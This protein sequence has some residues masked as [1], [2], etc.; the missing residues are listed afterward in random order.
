MTLQ[1]K[2]KALLQE[3]DLYKNQSLLNEAK[4]KFAEVLDLIK[5][6]GSSIK[7]V[8]NV[9]NA[10]SKKVEALEKEIE[11]MYKSATTP[12]VSEKAQNLIKQLFSFSN[13]GNS[14]EANLQAAIALAKFGQHERA[15]KEFKD[16]LKVDSMRLVAAKNVL[17]CLISHTS[18]DEAITQFREWQ[19]NDLFNPQELEKVKVF[20][21]GYFAKHG[22]EKDLFQSNA[23][24]NED[25]PSYLEDEGLD[26]EILDISSIAITLDNGPNKGEPV[27]LDVSFQ[28][29]NIISLIISSQDK[30]LIDNLKVGVKLNN[31][32]FYSP[33]AIFSGS[34]IVAEK[35]IIATGPKKGDYSLDIKVVNS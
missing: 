34:G 1:E 33:V 17:R 7:N 5:E 22:I 21:E 9:I 29:G 3:A 8:D 14:N 25:Q 35:S 6:K 26:E 16:L 31:V 4:D 13:S 28:A 30:S 27:E 2:I 24:Q 10:I 11:T 23:Q 12:I 15:I 19:S 20:L 18:I 32:H